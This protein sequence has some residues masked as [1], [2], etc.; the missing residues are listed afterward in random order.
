MNV[1]VEREQALLEYKWIYLILF[2]S[3]GIVFS[4][5]SDFIFS[6][7]YIGSIL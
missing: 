7:V 1:C 6:S 4:V 2:Q 3:M 5:I